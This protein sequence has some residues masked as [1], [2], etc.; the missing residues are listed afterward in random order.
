M[1]AMILI[2]L[3]QQYD[4]LLAEGLPEPASFVMGAI[5]RLEALER[6]ND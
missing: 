5:M 2:I 6:N 4:A 3:R 1:R